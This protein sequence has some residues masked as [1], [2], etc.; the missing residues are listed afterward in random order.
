MTDKDNQRDKST[1][2]RTDIADIVGI[3]AA[4]LRALAGAEV[5]ALEL[6]LEQRQSC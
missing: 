2:R 6:P 3:T 1:G 4:K 5:S